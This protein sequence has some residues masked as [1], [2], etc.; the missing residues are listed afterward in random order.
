MRQEGD[1]IDWYCSGIKGNPISGDEEEFVDPVLQAKL[2]SFVGEGHVTDEIRNDLL[3][4]G[5]IVMDD[6][7]EL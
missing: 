2:D 7:D 6:Q 3:K 5:W 4:L 1:Y